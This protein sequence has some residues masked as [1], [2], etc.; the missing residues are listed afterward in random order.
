MVH[1]FCFTIRMPPLWLV[2]YL[3]ATHVYLLFTTHTHA[4][5]Y[6]SQGTVFGYSFRRALMT[7]ILRDSAYMG[8]GYQARKIIYKCH[9]QT[10]EQKDN[11]SLFL[12]LL[13]YIYILLLLL[14]IYILLLF[15]MPCPFYSMIVYAICV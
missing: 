15:Y 12:L 6:F 8:Q 5:F 4:P 14:Y 13:L 3:S 11:P 2:Y 9:I 7:L 10:S 1:Q